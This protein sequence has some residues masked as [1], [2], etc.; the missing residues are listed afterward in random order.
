MHPNVHIQLFIK[1]FNT[2]RRGLQQARAEQELRKVL[3]ADDAPAALRLVLHDAATYDV[4]SGIGGLNGSIILRWVALCHCLS[5]EHGSRWHFH[6]V[7]Q[8]RRQL[9]VCATVRRLNRPENKNLTDILRKLESAKGAID[10]TSAAASM[11]CAW[12]AC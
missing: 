4:D 6:G 2:K 9:F 8:V 10:A 12:H 1:L 7:T 11:F 5:V 3:T